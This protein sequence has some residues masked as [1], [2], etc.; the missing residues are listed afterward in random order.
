MASMVDT[1]C[2]PFRSLLVDNTSKKSFK[3][4]ESKDA[5]VIPL[6][7][8]F[9]VMFS[10]PNADSSGTGM[11]AK[12]KLPVLALATMSSGRARPCASKPE[13]RI[14]S[15]PAARILISS[16]PKLGGTGTQPQIANR[17]S[18]KCIHTGFAGILGEISWV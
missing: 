4:P 14:E 2:R 18:F 11:P 15:S 5:G 6:L 3:F 1:N 12:K 8:E 9:K 16:N 7:C 17:G 10:A 13:V